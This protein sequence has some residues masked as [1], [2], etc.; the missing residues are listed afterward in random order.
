MSTAFHPQSDGQSE[1]TNKII[2]MYLRCLTGDCPRQWLQC[3]PWA[4]FYYNSS[5]Q[6]SL[7]TSPFRVVYG[8][9]PWTFRPFKPNSATLPAV[10]QQLVDRDEFLA[11]IHDRLEQAQQYHKAQYDRRHRDAIFSL[12]QWVWLCLIHR[13]TTSLDVH[14]RN[15]L[16][17]RFYGPFKVL[18]LI[19][20]VAYC[21]EL[22][23]I[24]RIHDVFYVR[25][26]KPY[27]GPEPT[28]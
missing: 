16:G 20:E 17:P 13:P 23:A 14:G 10:E 1:V 7:G 18:K 6:A 27:H 9:D 4:E 19:G 2:A 26:L 28:Q 11:E 22:P 3:L 25:L 15:K 5:F 12:G 21:L 24:A 8:W